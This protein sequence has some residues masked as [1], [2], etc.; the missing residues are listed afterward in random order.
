MNKTVKKVL[1]GILFIS[2]IIAF[3]FIGTRNFE[4]NKV[5]DNEKFDQEYTNVSK[6][7][8]FVYQNATEIYNRFR[9][10]SFI[11]FMGYPEN[12]WSG[13]YA[14]IVNEAAKEAGVKEIYYY[15]FKNDRDDKNGTYQS[16]VL[17]L[18]S[19]LPVIDDG[20]QNIY[21]PTLVVVKDGKVIN[22]N[23]DTAINIGRLNPEEYWTDLKIASKKSELILMF[24]DFL[25]K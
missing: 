1:Q 10:G 6:D 24:Q 20:E 13:Y 12:I 19:Y 25:T 9:N 18:A 17:K 4:D 8:V 11:L 23:N 3:I 21:A 14:N 5:V 2:I 16:I 22:Y 15:N 7:N